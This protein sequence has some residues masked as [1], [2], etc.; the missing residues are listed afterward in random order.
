MN[1]PP[2]TRRNPGILLGHRLM[3]RRLACRPPAPDQQPIQQMSHPV[4]VERPAQPGL[5]R[6][7]ADHDLVV[8]CML[9]CR[10]Q[11]SAA[12]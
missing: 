6:V 10:R 12:Q 7:Q 3:L 4:A 8:M 11:L 9:A 1:P 2:W 5:I